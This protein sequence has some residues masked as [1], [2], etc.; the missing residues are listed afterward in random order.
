MAFRYTRVG[1]LLESDP[2]A[3]YK[4]VRAALTKAKGH[5]GLAAARLG[6]SVRTLKGWLRRLLDAGLDARKAGYPRGRK[7]ALY[8][9]GAGK[10]EPQA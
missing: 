3:A 10:L 5:R 9:R 2:E 4:R 8:R 1:A 7:R 6:V